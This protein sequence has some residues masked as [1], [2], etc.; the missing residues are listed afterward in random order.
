[1]LPDAGLARVVSVAIFAVAAHLAASGA[2]EARQSLAALRQLRREL[3]ISPRAAAA[4]SCT[5]LRRPQ[6]GRL[7][8]CA[9]GLQWRS[10][11]AWIDVCPQAM[12]TRRFAIE[13][14]YRVRLACAR[15][16]WLEL[17]A[18]VVR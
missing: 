7:L 16:A 1:M 13:R 15:P 8:G 3:L 9:V 5:T 17:S 11:G 2:A 14:P 18:V 10:R 12:D 4:A 6:G